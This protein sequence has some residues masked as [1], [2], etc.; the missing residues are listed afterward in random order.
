TTTT[1]TA[2]TGAATGA[3]AALGGI[4][5]AGMVVG[6]AVCTVAGVPL[7]VAGAGLLGYGV[8]KWFRG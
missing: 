7:A 5:Q 6:G 8:Y 4:A 1:T 3:A 2:V